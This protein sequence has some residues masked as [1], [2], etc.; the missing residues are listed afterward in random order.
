MSEEKINMDEISSTEKKSK[1]T[2]LRL[3][4]E[5][6]KME[7]SE[8]ATKLYFETRF[9]LALENDDYSI[10]AGSAY[11]YGYMRAY[12]KLLN[13]PVDEF[14][15]ELKNI[16]DENEIQF[17]NLGENISYQTV[18]KSDHRKWIFPLMIGLLLVAIAVAG[19]VFMLADDSVN[20][21]ATSLHNETEILSGREFRSI[22]VPLLSNE[23]P[24]KN[25]VVAS[26]RAGELASN[27][28]DSESTA[29]I[30]TMVELEK[31]VMSTPRLLLEYKTDSWT[32]IRDA[33]GK[34]LVYRMVEK[35]NRL[36][37]DSS[38]TY[39][40][41]LG[42]SPGVNVSWNDQPF[43]LSDYESENIAYFVVGKKNDV[44]SD[45]TIHE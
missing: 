34:R 17:E 45:T 9:I 3:A 10:F 5:A 6:L 39:S 44:S 8:A 29:H 22:P 42:Y 32:D 7:A 27:N 19:Y 23:L 30:S 4:R 11:L 36:E 24:V 18:T 20:M 21:G 26:N 33:D 38:P 28:T 13:L 2:C 31:L 16:E 43:N 37:L 1:G 12:A 15:A 35:G 40:I 25:E 41:L 14:V